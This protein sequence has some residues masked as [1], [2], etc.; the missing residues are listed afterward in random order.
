M[1]KLA[2]YNTLLVE[3]LNSIIIV[4]FNRTPKMN[5]FTAETLNELEN[6]I[7]IVKDNPK[8]KVMILSTV[9][10]TFFSAGVDVSW[11]VSMTK[12]E[13]ISVSKRF[14]E[15]FGLLETLPIP[16]LSIVK[17]ICY[18]AGMEILYCSDMIF[19]T[20]NSQFAQ[21]EVK[22][23]ITPGAG[24][25][26]RLVRLVGP[27]KA[28][29]IIYSGLTISAEEAHR[30][31]LV[32]YIYSNGEIDAKVLKFAKTLSKNSS[33]AIKECKYL[34]QSAIYENYEGF[35]KEREVF[36]SDFFSGEPKELLSKVIKKMK[37]E[38]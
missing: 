22:F 23:G 27:L 29:E 8:I 6:V 38:K 1:D 32:N 9:S 26:Q 37:D 28:R 33:R 18:T 4:K 15:V 30:I 11:F 34:I 2:K 17:G 3:L 36:G 35:R 24:G 16:V 20:P 5:A 12:E 19:C 25:T 14:Q 31:G 13:A 7:H 21:L 10:D